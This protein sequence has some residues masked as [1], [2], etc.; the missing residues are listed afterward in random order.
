M[1]KRSLFLWALVIFL[2]LSGY[3]QKTWT[4]EE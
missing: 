1:K 3:A 4:L 2:P